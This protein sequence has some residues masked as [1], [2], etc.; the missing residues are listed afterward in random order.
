MT[1]DI[2][3]CYNQAIP[4]SICCDCEIREYEDLTFNQLMLILLSWI[5]LFTIDKKFRLEGNDLYLGMKFS[6]A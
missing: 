1:D 4:I 3:I 2:V 5:L 6:N